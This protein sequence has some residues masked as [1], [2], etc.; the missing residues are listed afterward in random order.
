MAWNQPNDD[1]KAR[2]RT[3]AARRSK[4]VE[5]TLRR[6]QGRLNALGGPNAP[7]R[8]IWVFLG[9]ALLAWAATGFYRIGPDERALVLRF[10][11]VVAELGPGAGLRWPLPIEVVRVL[12]VNTPKS[13]DYQ[14]RLLTDDVAAADVGSTLRY[15]PVDPRKILLA[16][17]DVDARVRAAGELA[18]RETIGGVGLATLLAPEQRAA[19]GQGAR[20]RAQQLLDAADAGVRVA[21]IQIDDVQMPSSVQPVQREMTKAAAARASEVEAARSYAAGV[22]PKAKA[23]AEKLVGEAEAASAR[24]VASA[25]AE[26]AHFSALVPAYTQAPEILRKRL[27]IETMES[28]L[29][30]ARKIVVDTRGTSGNMIYLPLDKLIEAGAHVAPA[31]GGAVATPPPA[32]GATATADDRGRERDQRARETR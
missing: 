8:V 26:A 27:Y 15:I 3:D 1:D 23:E 19:L 30:K 11:R 12:D 24:S 4:G 22:L 17:R 16:T 29:S 6:W 28:I 32:T 21:S 10:G 2:A 7:R 31:A 9:I 13:L 20:D 25:E 18:L 5:E 14:A